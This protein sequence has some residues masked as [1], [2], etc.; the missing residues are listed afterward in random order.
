MVKSLRAPTGGS[1]AQA[2]SDK[3]KRSP[4]MSASK[5]TRKGKD[6]RKDSGHGDMGPAVQDDRFASMHTSK[7]FNKIGSDKRK[8][9]L[10]SRFQG[11]LTDDKF[12]VEPGQVDKY[13]RKKKGSSVKQVEKELRDFYQI[14]QG[15]ESVDV[16]GGD[17]G[18]DQGSGDDSEVGSDV[19][20]N[21]EDKEGLP[22]AGDKD[23]PETRLDF[24]NRFARG[25]YEGS[26][27]DDSD[28]SGTDTDS[29]SE[30]SEGSDDVEDD[31]FDLGRG[32]MAVPDDEED[33]PEGEGSYRLALQNCDWENIR[34][35]DLQ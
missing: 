10:D 31:R 5:D 35:L 29:E 4:G 9:K 17:D 18:S 27:S 25:D 32:P 11:V 26:S 3:S 24:L 20:E 14:E 23:A 15:E 8:V 33:I 12:R 22:P 16:N 21:D 7:L 13:G 1:A 28:A 6:I 2:P 30:S 34:A 19:D